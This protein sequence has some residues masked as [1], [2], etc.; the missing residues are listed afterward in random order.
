M[1]LV[2]NEKARLFDT[3]AQTADTD[4]LPS[5]MT[6]SE[7]PAAFV[8]TVQVASAATVKVA[9][10]VSGTTKSYVLNDGTQLGA[11]ELYTFEVP[12]RDAGSYNIRLGSGVAID[13]LNVDEIP[14][15]AKQ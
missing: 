12:V 3:A 10:T 14:L 7:S 13:V 2:A 4:V 1:P 9:E 5:E 6:P 15:E 8:V 11:G